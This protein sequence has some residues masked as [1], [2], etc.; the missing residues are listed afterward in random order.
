M[1]VLRKDTV[2]NISSEACG[3]LF[4]ENVLKK[5]QN[6]TQAVLSEE[7]KVRTSLANM[8]VKEGGEGGVASR[9]GNRYF[10]AAHGEHHCGADVNNIAC[11]RS[12]EQVDI[13]SWKPRLVGG[14]SAGTGSSLT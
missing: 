5:K 11:W 9:A 13:C 10:S 3:R 6:A 2:L 8:K 4:C 14:V 7:Q 1:L 12:P